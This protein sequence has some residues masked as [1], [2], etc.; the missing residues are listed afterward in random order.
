[1][2]GDDAAP[3]QGGSN[4]VGWSNRLPAV[5]AGGGVLAGALHVASSVLLVGPG[6]VLD[7]ERA[8]GH[9]LQVLFVAGLLAG[10]WLLD[11]SDLDAAR[12]PRIARWVTGGMLANLAINLVLIGAF[13]FPGLAPNLQWATFAATMGAGIGLVIGGME[14]RAIQRAV[15]A[16]RE[17]VREEAL[18]AQRDWLDYLNSLLRHEVLNNANVIEG[19]AGLIDERTSEEAVA[20]HAAT[21]DRQARAMTDVIVDVRVL[22]EATREGATVQPVALRPVIA[23]ELSD[24]EETYPAVEIALDAP[25]EA[26]VAADPIVARVFANLFSNAVEHADSERP[27]VEVSV[28]PREETVA[29]RVADDGPGVPESL[30][31]TLFDRGEGDHGLGLYLVSVLVER[32]GGSVELT[33][34]GPDGSVFT[35]EL[36]RADADATPVAVETDVVETGFTPPFPLGHPAEGS[37]EDA[38][39]SSDHRRA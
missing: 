17:R 32:Y 39:P 36:P 38:P 1:M 30:R 25:E 3:D 28:E 24:L 37:G 26:I 13:G 33:E 7:H 21:I 2:G 27:R 31:D 29:V 6:A 34:T 14:A 4:S 18:E 5:L 16:E 22:L 9:G 12:Y 8:V 23:S 20:D 19:Y 10:A 11:R 35:V 15:V